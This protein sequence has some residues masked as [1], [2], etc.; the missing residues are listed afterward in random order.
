M[1]EN[2]NNNGRKG[3]GMNNRSGMLFCLVVALVMVLMFF[4]MM[5]QIE[6]STNKKV[7]YDTFIDM[8][9]EGKVSE[10]QVDSDSGRI[11]IFP[12]QDTQTLPNITIT[13]YTGILEDG[14]KIQ[15]RCDAAGV[16][17]SRVTIDKTNSVLQSILG[18]VLMFA[19]IYGVMFFVFRMISKSSGMMGVGKK[20]CEGLCGKRN[21]CD[22]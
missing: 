9:N 12:V 18:Y 19:V 6:E 2:E 21:R 17:Y 10:V 8:L 5:N 4:Y 16:T 22:I 1:G 11:L 3:K 14:N 7:S 20:Q 13:Y 15:E